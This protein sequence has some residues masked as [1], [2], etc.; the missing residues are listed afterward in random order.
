M[1]KLL[2]LLLLINSTL[3]TQEK[4]DVHKAADNAT[5]PLAFV[6]KLQFQPNY[7]LK[8]NG[9]DQ[10]VMISRIIILQ[11]KLAFAFKKISSLRNRFSSH[12]LDVRTNN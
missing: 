4:S 7:T 2:G 5:N 3:I 11:K 10:L 8:D 6:T 12:F 9:G 1:K